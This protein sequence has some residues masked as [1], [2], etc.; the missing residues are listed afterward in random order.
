M[1]SSPSTEA[2]RDGAGGSDGSRLTF[3]PEAEGKQPER[4]GLSPGPSRTVLRTSQRLASEPPAIV[5]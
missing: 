3:L 4:V 1:A 5:S 2:V